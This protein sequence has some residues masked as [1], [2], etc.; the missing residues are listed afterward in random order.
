VHRGLKAERSERITYPLEAGTDVSRC[1]Q[2]G[3]GTQAAPEIRA[4]FSERSLSTAGGNLPDQEADQLREAAVGELDSLQLRRD[5][6][7]LGRAAC[8]GSAP[9]AATLE[10]DREKSGLGQPIEAAARDVAVNAEHERDLVRGKRIAPASRVE[11][12]PAKLGIAG[13]CETVERHSEALER[14]LAGKLPSRR[15]LRTLTA[16]R[17]AV[18]EYA[19]VAMPTVERASVNTR[20]AADL[21]R[22]QR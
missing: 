12:N 6:V 3:C 18:G 7:D 20:A 13:R 19:H 2:A 17:K 11:E 10:R 4:R 1:L 22:A 9:V 5:A 21:C 14:H 16:P 8:S 15:D